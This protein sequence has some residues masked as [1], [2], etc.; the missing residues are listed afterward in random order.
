MAARGR[1]WRTSPRPCTSCVRLR[2][3]RGTHR[4]LRP[5]HLRRREPGTAPPVTPGS[6]VSQSRHARRAHGRGGRGRGPACRRGRGG[7]RFGHRAP[8]NSV[9]IG[10]ERRARTR[11]A[12]RHR[13]TFA[14]GDRSDTDVGAH[15]VANGRRQHRRRSDSARRDPATAHAATIGRTY[16][17]E[18]QAHGDG[19]THGER[20]TNGHLGSHDRPDRDSDGDSESDGKPNPDTHRGANASADG[21]SEPNRDP[22]RDTSAERLG[23]A[24]CLASRSR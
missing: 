8:P 7:S 19:C 13:P 17:T 14:D 5:A 10:G 15:C 1:R 16:P 22:D 21:N 23:S 9:G 12:R 4:G 20:I 3:M 18:P 24:T 11:G 2:R 6:A